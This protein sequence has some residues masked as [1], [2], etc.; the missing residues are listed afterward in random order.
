MIIASSTVALNSRS[1][2]W[3]DSIVQHPATVAQWFLK[4]SLIGFNL[5]LCNIVEPKHIYQ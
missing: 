2:E 4:K 3:S 1:Q 5:A